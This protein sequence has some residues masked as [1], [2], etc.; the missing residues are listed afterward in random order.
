[1][2]AIVVY[3]FTI[4]YAPHRCRAPCKSCRKMEQRRFLWQPLNCGKSKGYAC[5]FVL[6][7]RKRIAVKKEKLGQNVY[8]MIEMVYA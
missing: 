4:M 7:C 5:L 1:M 6:W 2:R 3:S 8:R